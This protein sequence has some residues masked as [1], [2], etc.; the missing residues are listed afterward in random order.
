[1]A[2]FQVSAPENFNFAHPD[3]WPKWIRRFERYRLASGL[4]SKSEEMQVNALIYYMGDQ[5]DDILLS[6][7]LSDE[8]KKK[9]NTVKGKFEGHFVIR[10]NTIYERAKF[11]QRRQLPGESVDNFITALYGLVE[12]CEYGALRE[13]MIRDRIVVGIANATLAEKLQLDSK[14]TLE[15]AIAKARESETVK[16]Q[17]SVVRGENPQIDR[18][19]KKPSTQK[20]KIP[21][22]SFKKDYC[23]RCGKS[24]PHSKQN[25]PAKDQTCHRCRRKGHF[26]SQCQSKSV[27]STVTNEP[28]QEGEDEL[29]LGTINSTN[30]QEWT[31]ELSLNGVPMTFKI[32]TGAEVTV[33]PESAATP[34]L[35]LLKSPVGKLHGP[36]ESALSVSGQF[37]GTLQLNSKIINE[38]IFIVKNLH[39]PLVGLPAIKALNLVAR[40]STINLN[41]EVILSQFSQLFSGLGRLQGEYEITLN[42]DAT[43]FALS[44]PR[45]IP[46][47]LMKEVKHELERMEKQNIISKVEG[48]SDWCAG[49]VVVPKPNK[50]VRICV[51]LTRLNNV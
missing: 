12:H 8:D 51:D 37:T 3:D 17:Q 27:V 46:L 9:Y 22:T 7:G 30:K 16:K 38:E 19:Y 23:T 13:E 11:N 26:Q 48:P 10:R 1:M 47:P 18:V 25:C 33:I 15:T 5:A 28:L 14:L 20:G 39:K 44:T 41:K 36:A 50:K 35:K 31:V 32:D 42:S 2:T 24:P 43:P 34:F 45:R 21:A 4:S 6:F 29:F 40:V 49:M